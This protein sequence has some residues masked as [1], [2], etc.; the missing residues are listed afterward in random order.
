MYSKIIRKIK[1]KIGKLS[2]GGK[3]F[4]PICNQRIQFFLP[5]R[6]GSADIPPFLR[7]MN[8]IGSDVENFTCPSCTSHDRERHLTLYLIASGVLNKMRGKNILH[9][10]PEKNLRKLIFPLAK[11]YVMGDLCPA[12]QEIEKINLQKVDYPD[13]SFDFVIA[14]HVLEH[15]ENDIAA[16]NEIF[17]ITRLGGYA[18]LQTPY[19]NVLHHTF[20]DPGI[21][22]EIAR[23]NAYG[24]EDHQR[25]YGLDL[26]LRI[27]SSGFKSLIKKHSDLLSTVD[28]GKLGIN[29]EEPF[30]LFQK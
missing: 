6:G 14:N 18:I 11:K 10:A 30:F 20:C 9:I 29:P 21:K 8:M 24:Q 12:E 26:P 13:E 19:S 25:L 4:C 23:L 7:C 15:V 16:L 17:R 5:Y 22:T 3:H 2:L 27:Q 28:S 1:A